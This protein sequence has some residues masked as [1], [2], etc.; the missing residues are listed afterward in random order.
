M[1]IYLEAEE[2]DEKQNY[3]HF[4]LLE[5]LQN[6]RKLRGLHILK[7]NKEM[8][9]NCTEI[10]VSHR[11]IAVCQSLIHLLIPTLISF[12]QYWFP[13]RLNIVRNK[14]FQVSVIELHQRT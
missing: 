14:R 8:P 13:L 7:L 4:F 10:S 1:R 12:L 9:L 3:F 11:Y 6:I 2:G 5:I